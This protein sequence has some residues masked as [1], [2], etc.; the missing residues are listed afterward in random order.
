MSSLIILLSVGGLWVGSS[1]PLHHTALST[2]GIRPA[3]YMDPRQAIL[4][5]ALGLCIGIFFLVRA[6]R[7]RR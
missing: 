2:G 3:A 6:V 4:G 5:S 1:A 7:S